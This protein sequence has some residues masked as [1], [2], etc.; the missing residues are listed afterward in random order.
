MLR[1]AS[2]IALAIVVGACAAKTTTPLPAPSAAKFPEFIQPPVP[3]SL[4]ANPA[5]VT[6]QQRGWQFLQAGDLRNAEREFKLALAVAPQFYPAETSLGYLELARKEAG[7]ALPHFEKA[8]ALDGRDVSALVGGGLAF[9]ALNRESDALFAFESAAAVDPS[10]VDIKRRV[11]VLRFRGLGQDL[12][13]AR[14]AAADGKL[15]DAARAYASAIASSPD[16]PFLYRELAVVERRQGNA[17]AALGDFRKALA[18]DPTDA[19]SSVGVGDLLAEIGD[20]EGAEKAY[21]DALLLEPSEAVD[22]KLD[23]L[24]ARIELARLPAEYR[25][26]DTAAQITR[27]DLAALIGVRLA[28]LVQAARRRDAI[29]ITDTRNHWASTWITAVARAGIVDPYDNHTF[30]PRSVVRRTDLALAMS[31]LLSRVAAANPAQGRA[32]ESA[33]VRFSDLSPGHLA[34]PAASMAVAAG[35]MRAGADNAFFPTQIVN[36][37]EAVAA[38]VRVEQLASVSPPPGGQAQ[39]PAAEGPR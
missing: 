33:R 13:A 1:W 37:A 11:E 28:P 9:L 27:G 36:G 24:R 17:E 3:R 8:L 20:L 4:A 16:S 39:A 26:I 30:Q 31:R 15:D 7:D 19:G 25:A 6:S 18:L 2:A 23:G 35:V 34:Y 21:T 32:W 12:A 29:V 14:Q 22:A 10:L 5:A 38:I